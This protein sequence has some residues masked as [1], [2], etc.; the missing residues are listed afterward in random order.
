MGRV[1]ADK[2]SYA[3]GWCSRRRRAEDKCR[4]SGT[5][6]GEESLKSGR[7]A[8]GLSWC[9]S[10]HIGASGHVVAVELYDQ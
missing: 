8:S 1:A 9:L 6:T 10:V 3:T 5:A 2:T 4:R 7:S